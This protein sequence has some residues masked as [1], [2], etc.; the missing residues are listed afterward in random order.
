[1]TK[2]WGESASESRKRAPDCLRLLLVQ[3]LEHHGDREDVARLEGDLLAPVRI[4]EALAVEA[5]DPPDQ[6]AERGV[7]CRLDRHERRAEKFRQGMGPQREP[8]HHAEA[9]AIAALDPRNRSGWVQVLAILTAPSAVTTSALS[10]LAAAIP[11]AFE[12][13]PKPPLWIR[14]ATPTVR[15]PPPWT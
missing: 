10:R 11:Y 15:H 12:K 1:M 4:E 7:R 3:P 5:D 2:S 13:L 14:L 6:L 9:T 8:G